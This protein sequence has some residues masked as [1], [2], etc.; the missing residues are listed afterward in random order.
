MTCKQHPKFRNIH[1]EKIL[2]CNGI[3]ITNFNILAKTSPNDHFPIPYLA[4]FSIVGSQIG[5]LKISLPLFRDLQTTPIIPQIYKSTAALPHHALFRFTPF[6]VKIFET[7]NLTNGPS[8]LLRIHCNPIL[9]HVRPLF[10]LGH[11]LLALPH[12]CH[13][14]TCL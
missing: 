10:I 8:P 3:S 14:R 1:A 13:L 12:P 7:C 2:P 4:T 6:A 9:K 11:S 5:G